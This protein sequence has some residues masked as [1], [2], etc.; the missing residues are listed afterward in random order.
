MQ[1]ENRCSSPG[2]ILTWLSCFTLQPELS[3]LPYLTGG[4]CPG[5]L[6]DHGNGGA[7]FSGT[8][9][10]EHY[11]LQYFEAAD[12]RVSGIYPSG[13]GLISQMP[14]TTTLRSRYSREQ[15]AAT[16]ARS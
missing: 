1:D 13:T 10:E 5:W 2:F 15:L 12:V 8:V 3:N 6:I 4:K 14:C 7:Y 9:E 11:R 16:L